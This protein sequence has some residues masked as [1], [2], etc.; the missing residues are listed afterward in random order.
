MNDRLITL[1]GDNFYN[2]QNKTILIV[3][4]GGVGGFCLES[5]VRSG[6]GKIII[7]DSDIVDISNLNRQIMSTKSNVGL[8]K[9][10]VW[11]ARIKKISD[12]EVL[13]F[14]LFVDDSNIVELFNN[15][16]IDYVIDTC[17]TVNTK[18]EL[19]KYCLVNNIKIISSMGMANR[20]DTSKIKISLLAKTY[21]DPLARKLRPIFKNNKVNV[22]FSDEVPLKSVKLGSLC[23]VVGVAGLMIS[24]YVINDLIGDL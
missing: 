2:L 15:N 7:V 18:I 12:C 10:D 22:V 9:V 23:S 24:N 19:L 13:A 3:G 20:V 21:N 16:N 8:S 5:L 6:I 11:K 17:D 14:N 1:L 4:V